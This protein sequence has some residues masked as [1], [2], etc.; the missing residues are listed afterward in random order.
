M[1]RRKYVGQSDNRTGWL[2][3]RERPDFLLELQWVGADLD[4]CQHIRVLSNHALHDFRDRVQLQLAC[5]RVVIVD[6]VL[7]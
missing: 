5:D 1:L 4:P 3:P 7:E 6:L 2:K